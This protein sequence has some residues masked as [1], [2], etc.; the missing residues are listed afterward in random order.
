MFC[1]NCG[2]QLPDT[3]RFCSSCGKSVNANTSANVFSTPSSQSDEHWMKEYLDNLPPDEHD[4]L[5]RGAAEAVAKGMVEPVIQAVGRLTNAAS[6]GPVT[7]DDFKE[8]IGIYETIEKRDKNPSNNRFYVSLQIYKDADIVYSKH[9]NRWR[10]ATIQEPPNRDLMIDDML[11][12]INGDLSNFLAHTNEVDSG[13]RTR[14][15]MYPGIKRFLEE[16]L[17]SDLL[18]DLKALG[19]NLS[20][21]ARNTLV[22]RYG[23]DFV[24][25]VEEEVMRLYD[26]YMGSENS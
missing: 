26:H 11:E 21:G 5:M 9:F 17:L 13:T 6:S 8:A 12:F 3:A 15:I 10:N 1:M 18:F 22:T 16:Y 4:K 24:R 2:T 7:Y 19:A 25:S 23:D 14:V 20:D